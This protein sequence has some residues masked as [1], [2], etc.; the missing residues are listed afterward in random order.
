MKAAIV[1]CCLVPP[2]A[3]VIGVKQNRD[4]DPHARWLKLH[5]LILAPARVAAKLPFLLERL[6]Y[7]FGNDRGAL[8]LAAAQLFHSLVGRKGDASGFANRI[9]SHVNDSDGVAIPRENVGK[10]LGYLSIL[11]INNFV[12]R[13]IDDFRGAGVGAGIACDRLVPS[14]KSSRIEPLRFHASFH[15]P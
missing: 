2:A 15:F 6:P 11:L 9:H 10:N 1:A 12:D 14:I 5:T 7:G 4:H 3:A 8:P 13:G